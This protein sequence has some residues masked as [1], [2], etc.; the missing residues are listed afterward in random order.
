MIFGVRCHSG[1][2]V[3]EGPDPRHQLVLLLFIKESHL[4]ANKAATSQ[5]KSCTQGLRAKKLPALLEMDQ[6]GESMSYI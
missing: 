2:A 1:R 5:L 6:C 4:A 3:A